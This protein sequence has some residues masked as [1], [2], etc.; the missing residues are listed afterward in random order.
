ME[1]RAS[2]PSC[3][4]GTPGAPSNITNV[5]PQEF[6]HFFQVRGPAV[7]RQA[8]HKPPPVLLLQNPVVEQRQQAA[9]VQRSNQSPKSLL[10]RNNRARHLVFKES[11]AAASV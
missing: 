2:R 11:V 1:R 9:I 10:Q 3:R 4:A 5:R 7:A 6:L 8:L